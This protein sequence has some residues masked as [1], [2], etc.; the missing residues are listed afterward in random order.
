MDRAWSPKFSELSCVFYTWRVKKC[1]VPETVF[2][3]ESYIKLIVIPNH[4]S[5]L[6][7]RP[8][9]FLYLFL[10][11]DMTLAKYNMISKIRIQKEGIARRKIS[12]I[13]MFWHFFLRLYSQG[14]KKLKIYFLIYR[15]LISHNF[16]QFQFNRS[17]YMKITIFLI[18]RFLFC[19]HPLALYTKI[20]VD[21][22]VAISNETVFWSFIIERAF[23]RC[24]L[25]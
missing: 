17:K 23:E 24:K 14:R 9:Y 19:L 16:H 21:W 3:W 15:H 13:Q 1:R 8:T 5:G 22:V 25:D 4:L 20:G 2:E 7:A 12:P 11:W 18:N 6:W 10:G